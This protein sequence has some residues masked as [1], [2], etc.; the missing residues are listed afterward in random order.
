MKSGVSNFSGHSN[1]KLM[2]FIPD[3]ES[4]NLWV[5]GPSIGFLMRSISDC[6]R[7][8]ILISNV[9]SH[10]HLWFPT[11]IICVFFRTTLR[12]S[13]N[14]SLAELRSMISQWSGPGY[15][16]TR[17]GIHW[18]APGSFLR[19]SR[20]SGPWGGLLRTDMNGGQSVYL[21]F[22]ASADVQVSLGD[23]GGETHTNPIKELCKRTG[24]PRPPK[25]MEEELEHPC[26]AWGSLWFS[27]RLPWRS[28]EQKETLRGFRSMG[29]GAGEGPLW[30]RDT[31]AWTSRRNP[32]WSRA[33]QTTF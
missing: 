30:Q 2:T 4:H 20:G 19:P 8:E 11:G 23:K 24:F 21:M 7:W 5:W 6:Y 10:F 22:P 12:A 33:A 18:E 9:Q 29:S 15:S 28:S 16:I 31:E 14:S 1:C 25:A 3:L 13:V 26:W 27:L 32:P 17:L